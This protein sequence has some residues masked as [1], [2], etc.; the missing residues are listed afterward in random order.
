MNRERMNNND[1]I[2][3]LRYAVDLNDAALVEIFKLAGYE[4]TYEEIK[5][6]FK[7]E[8]DEGYVEL[9]ND[10]MDLF[11]DGFITYRRGKQESKPG[12]PAPEKEN[13]NNNVIF[14][15]LRIALAL[16]GDDV[17]DIMRLSDK[18]ISSSE[19]SAI[20][21]KKDHRNYKNC[22][23]R[24]IRNFLKGLTIQHRGHQN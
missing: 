24:Y 10:K 2:R 16:R 22:G 21:R 8:G 1:I 20:F 23:D 11:L 15:K 4:L 12:Q 14:K 13:L 17:L 5:S 7:K 19:L 18:K 6:M 3:R 9:T